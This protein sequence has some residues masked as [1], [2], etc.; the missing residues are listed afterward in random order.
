MVAQA[1]GAEPRA[2][3]EGAGQGASLAGELQ[4]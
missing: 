4:A 2:V 1:E 3:G